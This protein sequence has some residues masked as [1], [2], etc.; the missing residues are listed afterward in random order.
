LKLE[1]LCVGTELLNG[2]KSDAHTAYLGLELAPLGLRP[3]RSSCVGDDAAEIRQAMLDALGRCELLI[4]CGGLGPTLD[5]IS[6]DVA[7]ALAGRPLKE[8]PAL[9]AAPGRR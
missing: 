1:I 7:A 9:G 2:A 4:V 3:S 8:D 5:D 6:R